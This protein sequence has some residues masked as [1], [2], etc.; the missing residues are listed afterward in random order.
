MKAYLFSLFLFLIYINSYSQDSQRRVLGAFVY[1]HNVYNYEFVKENIDIYSLEISTKAFSSPN[2]T[3][4][5][6][7]SGVSTSGVSTSSTVK[8][9]TSKSNENSDDNN[10]F[11]EFTK[12]TFVEVFLKQMREKF[13]Y[14]TLKFLSLKDQGI[15]LFFKIK[16][17]LEFADDEPLTAHLILRRDTTTSLLIAND[18]V[19]H[20]TGA[21][22]ILKLSHKV[23]RVTIEIEDG[24]MKNIVARLIKMKYAD[25]EKSPREYLE[26]KNLFPVSISG[27]FDPE[28]FSTINLLCQNCG[29]VK[30]VTRSMSLSQLL[31]FSITLENDKEDYSPANSVFSLS[32]KN[33]I[34]ELRKEKRSKILEVAAFTDFL[35]LDGSQPN[36]LIQIE[37]RRRININTHFHLNKKTQRRI[38]S[39]GLLADAQFYTADL[40]SGSTVIAKEK[41]GVRQAI[42]ISTTGVREGEGLSS[43]PSNNTAIRTEKKDY[44]EYQVK[45]RV[46]NGLNQSNY[47]LGSDSTIEDTTINLRVNRHDNSYRYTNWLGSIEPKLLFSKLE[48]TNKYLLAQRISNQALVSPKDIYRYQLSSF[49][50]NLNVLKYT[51]PQIKFSWTIP[52]IG[53]YWFRNSIISYDKDNA[54]QISNRDTTKFVNSVYWQLGTS[55]QFK[56]DSRWGLTAGFNYMWINIWDSKIDLTNK[57]GLLQYNLDAFLKTNEDSNSRLFFRFRLTHDIKSV[58]SNFTQMQLGYLLDIFKGAKPVNK[59][60]VL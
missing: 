2:V 41:N 7:T 47:D 12:E 8:S 23:D 20:Y 35:G 32:P 26:F 34:Q 57:N 16:T 37:A 56:P 39:L 4:A 22:S 13:N 28:Y 38:D 15:S 43:R 50:F 45:L 40:I 1:N 29:S 10:V 54:N 46:N 24:A 9:I 58:N 42:P 36:G 18:L 60:N 31:T 48:E 11:N 19:N 5:G 49:G 6:S 52:Y 14:D 17:R 27:K 30:G 55:F 44:Y 25:N 53:V 21:L 33:S 3:T 59:N 51:Y